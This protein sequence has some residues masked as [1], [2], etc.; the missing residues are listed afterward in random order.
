MDREEQ[1]LR[2]ECKDH[3]WYHLHVPSLGLF[4]GLQEGDP[5]KINQQAQLPRKIALRHEGESLTGQIHPHRNHQM[6]LRLPG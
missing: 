2:T 5:L 1:E 3:R 4:R 6:D